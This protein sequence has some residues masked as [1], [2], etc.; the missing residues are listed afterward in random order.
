MRANTNTAADDDVCLQ[1]TTANESNALQATWWLYLL[2]CTDGRTYIGIALD[3]AARF[4]AH[5]DGKGAKFTRSNPPLAIL[6]AQP[7]PDKST[8][9]QAE[10]A[11]KQ[12][13]RTAKLNWAA[14]WPYL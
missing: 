5:A 7:F 8:V 9:L 13:D 1:A 2:A 14:Q 6:G 11:L 10:Y 4:R 3:V 12:L